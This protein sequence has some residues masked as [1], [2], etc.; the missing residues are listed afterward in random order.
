MPRIL[1]Y[2]LFINTIVNFL[3]IA[4]AIFVLIKQIN[5]LTPP[6]APVQNRVYAP[7]AKLQSLT[8]RPVARTVNFAIIKTNSFFVASKALLSVKRLFLFAKPAHSLYNV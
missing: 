8:M 6:P 2:G 5:R 7:S 1:A 3:I 4:F